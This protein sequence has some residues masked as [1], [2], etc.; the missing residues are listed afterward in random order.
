MVA[1]LGLGAW[2]LFLRPDGGVK[3]QPDSGATPT[4][5]ASPS[6]TAVADP[7]MGDD[8]VAAFRAIYA[9]RT[10]AF[11]ERRPELVDEIYRPDCG[12]YELKP[13][14]QRATASGEH[15]RGYDP[16]VLKVIE[17]RKVEPATPNLA[18]V[19]VITEQVPFTIE[20]DDG[21]VIA[22]DPGWPPQST[23]WRLVKSRDA[24]PW[25]VEFMDIEG[26]AE[27]VLGNNWRSAS[28]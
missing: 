25:K 21:R 26:T 14:V 15:V 17:V 22:E 10:R 6:P 1:L 23:Y 9:K 28:P 18:S 16:R 12:C 19:R 3:P 24:G 8:P 11:V 2:L 13:I 5:T 4:P 20:A 27:E 7:Q